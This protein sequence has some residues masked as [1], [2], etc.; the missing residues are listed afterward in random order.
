M[1]ILKAPIIYFLIINF[2][3][4]QQNSLTPIKLIAPTDCTSSTQFYDISSSACRN[5]P[6]NSQKKD[7]KNFPKK[8][9]IFLIIFF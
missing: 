2:A 5:C 7:R 3:T 1:S 6:P 8:K 9:T 4:C